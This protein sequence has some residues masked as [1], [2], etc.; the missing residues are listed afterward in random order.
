MPVS[1]LLRAPAVRNELEKRLS[2]NSEQVQHSS[3]L[4]TS[5]WAWRHLVTLVR[6]AKSPGLE[7]TVKGYE[8]SHGT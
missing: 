8:M 4:F 5:E 6:K 1:A 2:K 3:L 7:T